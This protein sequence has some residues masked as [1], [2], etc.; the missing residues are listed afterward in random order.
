MRRYKTAAPNLWVKYREWADELD[1][2]WE[3][4]NH[5]LTIV[6]EDAEI[7]FGEMLQDL[8]NDFRYSFDK[9]ED[10]RAS[11]EGSEIV[12]DS[13]TFCIRNISDTAGSK[14][15]G[16]DEIQERF[17]FVAWHLIPEVDD[18]HAHAFTLKECFGN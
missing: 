18:R 16:M 7:L 1:L 11:S 9:L 12:V 13:K 3:V 4:R 8:H 5:V 17:C 14:I 6:G 15:P 2:T 10:I